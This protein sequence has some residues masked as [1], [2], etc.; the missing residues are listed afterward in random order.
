MIYNIIVTKDID[1]NMYDYIEPWGETLASVACVIISS[2]HCTLGLTLGWAV[3]G[4][5]MLFNLTLI[6]D[7]HV[8]TA[9]KQQQVDNYNARKF[10]ASQA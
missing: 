1:R 10:Q 2:F 5:D 4:R 6:V 7:W 9:R 3:F 8:V